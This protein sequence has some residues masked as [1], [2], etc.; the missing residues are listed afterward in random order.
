MI[1]SKS[2]LRAAA[3]GKI[4]RACWRRCSAWRSATGREARREIGVGA[5]GLVELEGRLEAR[6]AERRLEEARRRGD[7]VVLDGDRREAGSVVRAQLLEERLGGAAEELR[8][9]REVLEERALRDARAPTHLRGGR[10]RP[11]ERR[12]ALEGRLEEER[13]GRC[14]PFG[15]RAPRAGRGAGPSDRG[16]Y[17]HRCEHRR[18]S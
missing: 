2:G 8:L 11:A 12:E 18:E 10:V 14:A 7:L 5:R 6:L 1:A 3:S 13:A 15:L 9:R 16:V 17:R 4:S